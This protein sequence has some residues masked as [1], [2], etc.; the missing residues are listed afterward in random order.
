MALQHTKCNIPKSDGD[1][2]PRTRVLSAIESVLS[3]I[4]TCL[5]LPVNAERADMSQTLHIHFHLAGLFSAREH[6]TQSGFMS[7]STSITTGHG[8][9]VLGNWMARGLGAGRLG[10]SR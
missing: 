1:R 3:P 5:S 9:E 10:N 2:L 8:N 7:Q 6:R 4:Q